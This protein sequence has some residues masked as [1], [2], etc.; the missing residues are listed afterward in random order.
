MITP[1]LISLFT[2]IAVYFLDRWE[3][4]HIKSL[5]D[6]VPAILLAYVIPA[7]ISL[8]LNA[9]FSQGTIHNYSKD[10]FI[11]L[12]IIAVM[13]SLSLGQ[14]KSIGWK[15]IVLFVS[16]SLIIATLPVLLI[17]GFSETNLI[18]DTL[19]Q[20][21][22][23]KGIP[24]I[25]GSWIG[26]S[27]S[28][29]VLKELVECPENIFLSVLVMDTVL[30]NIWTILMFQCIK[31]SRYL[32]T[33]FK[34]SDIALP[35]TIRTEE[36]KVLSPIWCGCLML[37]F[38]VLCNWLF[39]LFVVKIVVL[40]VLGLLLGNVLPSWNFRFAL[41][42]GGV[43]ILVVMAIL[44]LKL[45]IKTLGFDTQFLGF[46]VVWLLGHF[47]F[48]MGLSKALNLNMAW[49]PIASMA[50]VGGIATAPAVTAAYNK[51]W[52]PHAIVLAIL[53][54]ATGTFWGMLT[55]FLLEFLVQ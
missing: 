42:A 12:A 5:F 35:E 44:G 50:N 2:V 24:P 21:G 32:N 27:T 31:K 18:T 13:S 36:R 10:F 38:V 55:I 41:R 19:V 15:P 46:L 14:L 25:V 33:L 28:Q 1:W 40:S 34:I 7:L 6:W 54:M 49:V 17:V 16:G 30:V 29:L 4:K 39:S 11:P 45:Q 23:W 26:G 51:K 53:S 20:E 43:L 3:N 47:V 22:Y 52:M 9:D 48:M 8:I 37:I